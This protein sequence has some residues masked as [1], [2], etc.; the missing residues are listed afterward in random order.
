MSLVRILFR[1]TV[2]DVQPTERGVVDLV[3]RADQ[4]YRSAGR[5]LL[6]YIAHALYRAGDLLNPRDYNGL[7]RVV[8]RVVGGQTLHNGHS[9]RADAYVLN[10]LPVHLPN[11]DASY[12][13]FFAYEGVEDKKLGLLG[14][15]AAG[16]SQDL[17]DT[18]GRRGNGLHEGAGGDHASPIL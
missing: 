6:Q 5:R 11:G 13:A 16:F 8:Q 12:K 10:R 14:A 3:V 7:P 17:P 2:I 18:L 15:A 1:G 9:D 4:Q